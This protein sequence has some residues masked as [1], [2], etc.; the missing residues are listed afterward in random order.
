MG[1]PETWNLD[2][3]C[4]FDVSFYLS[5]C[6]PFLFSPVQTHPLPASAFRKGNIPLLVPF[7]AVSSLK[8]SGAAPTVDI[9][10]KS[11]LG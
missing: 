5:R 2:V 8:F 9:Q 1:C 3:M 10:Q 7:M 11:A 6:S 4:E